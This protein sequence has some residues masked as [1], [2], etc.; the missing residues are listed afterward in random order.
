M[1]VGGSLMRIENANIVQNAY[2][3]AVSEQAAAGPELTTPPSGPGGYVSADGKTYF[4]PQAVVR[5]RNNNRQV[6]D[7]FFDAHGDVCSLSVGFDLVRP[8]GVPDDAIALLPDEL[9]VRLVPTSGQPIA[10]DNVQVEPASGVDPKV[11]QSLACVTTV[12]VNSAP[13]IMR[14][15]VGAYFDVGGQV[16]YSLKP[17]ASGGSAPPPASGGGFGGMRLGRMGALMRADSGIATAAVP[18]A[19]SPMPVRYAAFRIADIGQYSTP[20][21][22]P[23]SAPNVVATR[24]ALGDAQRRGV[25]AYFPTDNP[26]NRP[27]YLKVL[28]VGGD[29]SAIFKL[30]P[31]GHCQPTSTPNE[32]YIL[33]DSFGLAL[34]QDTGLPAMSVLLVSTPPASGATPTYTVRIRFNIAPVLDAAR[35]AALRS[36]LRQTDEVAYADL[37]IGGYAKATFSPSN[38]YKSLGQNIVGADASAAIEVDAANGFELVMDCSLQLYTLLARND[39]VTATGLKGG[40]VTITI[41]TGPNATLDLSVPVRL[42]LTNPAATPLR[43]TLD[44]GGNIGT[45]HPCTLA[46][47]NTCSARVIAG[48]IFATLLLMD[49][50]MPYPASASAVDAQPST[51][52]LEGAGNATIVLTAKPE[53][54]G[55]NPKLPPWSAVAVDF[56]SVQIAFD[57][58]KV[59]ARIHELAGASGISSTVRVRSFAL[60]H[61]DQLPAQLANKLVGIHVQLQRGADKPIDAFLTAD[62]SQQDVQLALSFSDLVAGLSPTEPSFQW[63]QANIYAVSTGPWSDWTQNTGPQ[64]FVVPSDN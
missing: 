11:A 13:G 45:D 16:H 51:I 18:T 49:Q 5:S 46:V 50:K 17:A 37:K 59:L 10:F 19:P 23:P 38:F 28:D 27:I 36:W 14:T 41:P 15:D 1:A 52:D 33:P 60:A 4:V 12:D 26:H 56:G 3:R 62:Q 40:D 6:P 54:T 20:S 22:S 55:G 42:T 9:A 31:N 64:L 29:T 7:V 58:S 47:T 35:I 8:D 48:Q 53:N 34:D 30:T 24:V 39:L 2:G 43:V 44:P 61:M 57:P 25:G 21:P 63:R 32:Y